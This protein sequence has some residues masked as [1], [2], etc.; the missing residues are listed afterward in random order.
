MA[1]ILTFCRHFG[2]HDHATMQH[3]TWLSLLMDATTDSTEN[4]NDDAQADDAMGNW[5]LI[6]SMVDTPKSV[7]VSPW[8]RTQRDDA[9]PTTKKPSKQKDLWEGTWDEVVDRCAMKASGRNKDWQCL[10]CP[11]AFDGHD[12]W[13]LCQH[14]E[15]KQGT[16]NHPTLAQFASWKAA[17]DKALDDWE[18]EE[19]PIGRR[20]WGYS[21]QQ[22]KK[23]KGTDERK[24]KEWDGDECNREQAAKKKRIRYYDNHLEAEQEKLHCQSLEKVLAKRKAVQAELAQLDSELEASSSSRSKSQLAEPQSQSLPLTPSPPAH[25]PPSCWQTPWQAP[26]RTHETRLHPGVH[27]SLPST[28]RILRPSPPVQPSP[29]HMKPQRNQRIHHAPHVMDERITVTKT[30]VQRRCVEHPQ[31]S[32]QWTTMEELDAW[33]EQ[34][35]AECQPEWPCL[36]GSRNPSVAPY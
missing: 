9:E 15:K 8:P 6:E 26:P 13:P 23:R 18:E 30:E 25:A 11:R 19:D 3:G 35:I 7:P 17:W 28:W 21:S 34:A 14:L 1:Y 36:V 24:R 20:E 12:A 33:D 27:F 10:G 32:C 29:A 4:C 16:E 22:G 2:P 5:S 31:W